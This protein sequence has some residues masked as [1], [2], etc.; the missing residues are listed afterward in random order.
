MTR[1]PRSAIVSVTTLLAACAGNGEGLDENGRPPDGM[2]SALVAEFGSIQDNVFTP[3][4]T[5]CHAGAAAPLGLRLEEGVA[6]AMLVNAPSSEVP[7]LLRVEPGN[8]DDSYLVQK[9]EGTASVGGRMPLD[10]AAL[11]QATIDVIR[12]WIIDGAQPPA[13]S[14]SRSPVTLVAAEPLPGATLRK[15]PSEILLSA[16]G[17]LDLSLIH[18]SSVQ[19]SRSGGDGRFDDGNDVPVANQVVAR[20]LAPT[21]LAVRVDEDAWVADRYRLV[22]S[23]TGASPV[24]DRGGA[25]IDGDADGVPGGD[26]TLQFDLEPTP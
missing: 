24:A 25:L 15:A 22:V 18:P 19:L 20:L 11:P 16:S 2:R 9:L 14:T 5:G 4:C 13:G 10:G 21:V 8:P 26:F 23:G 1:C 12:Q 3:S 6:Y 7:S 17:E